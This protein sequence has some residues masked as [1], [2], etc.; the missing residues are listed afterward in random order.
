MHLGP[1]AGKPA[2]AQL[3]QLEILLQSLGLLQLNA[4]KL[5]AYH[6]IALFIQIQKLS[7]EV[8]PS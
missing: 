1:E 4:Y 2:R 5:D 6:S 7:K 8:F 3:S